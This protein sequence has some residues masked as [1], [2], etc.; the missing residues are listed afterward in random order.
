M[1]SIVLVARQGSDA[2]GAIP[3][4][5]LAMPYSG[6]SGPVLCAGT[7]ALP[8]GSPSGSGRESA[9]GGVGGVQSYSGGREASLR[10]YFS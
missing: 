10:S 8:S 3:S 2:D 6:H 9:E 1:G 5:A 4:A 7:Q